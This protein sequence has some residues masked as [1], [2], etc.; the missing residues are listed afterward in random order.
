MKRR[1]STRIRGFSLLSFALGTILGGFL[2]FL[3]NLFTISIHDFHSGRI[4]DENF[5]MMNSIHAARPDRSQASILGTLSSLPPKDHLLIIAVDSRGSCPDSC[6][7]APLIFPPWVKYQ[8]VNFQ[9]END[10]GQLDDVTT[11]LLI[12]ARTNIGNLAD[13]AVK[14]RQ[15]HNRSVG[16]W[17][18]ADERIFAGEISGESFA[19]LFVLCYNAVCLYLSRLECML[20]CHLHILKKIV[21]DVF[22]S[23]KASIINLIMSSD[24]TTRTNIATTRTGIHFMMT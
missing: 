15:D 12:L 14:R 8:Y 5:A 3:A 19:C 10:L 2:V 7:F 22:V 24:T 18:M 4:S 1:S 17:H 21:W 6:R 11:H 23:I 16:L 9:N 20:A 13:Y